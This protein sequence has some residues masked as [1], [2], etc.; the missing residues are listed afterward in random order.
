VTTPF[1]SQ[2]R[3]VQKKGGGKRG[4]RNR[5]N[6]EK[7][8][9]PSSKRSNSEKKKHLRPKVGEN[10]APGCTVRE[11]TNTEKW[12]SRTSTFKGGGGGWVFGEH[13]KDTASPGLL[14]VRV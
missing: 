12:R 5:T 11:K 3:G 2:K 8:L 1:T 9:P 13:R 6:R 4:V 10:N 14:Q 7:K